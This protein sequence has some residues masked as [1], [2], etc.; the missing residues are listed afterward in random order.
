MTPDSV[1]YCIAFAKSREHTVYREQAKLMLE[2]L[3]NVGYFF[4]CAVVFTNIKDSPLLDEL[5]D[6]PYATQIREVILD[7]DDFSTGKDGKLPAARFRIDAWQH[8]DHWRGADYVLYLDTDCIIRKPLSC[9]TDEMDKE[10]LDIMGATVARRNMLRSRWFNGHIPPILDASAAITSPV[11]SGTIL[12][13]G[14]SFEPLCRL[15]REFDDGPGR[16]GVPPHLVT[17]QSSHNLLHLLSRLDKIPFRSGR[18]SVHGVA[19]PH[20]GQR[21]ALGHF[22]VNGA[23]IWHFWHLPSQEDRVVAMR[24]ELERLQRMRHPAPEG[25]LGVWS[26]EKPKEKISNRWMFHECGLIT[27]D[28]PALCGRWEWRPSESELTQNEIL[29]DWLWGWEKIPLGYVQYT[30]LPPRLFGESFRNGAFT[31]ERI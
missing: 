18:F 7:W 1:V 8:F 16:P 3:F 9:L 29:I 10:G 11:Q 15:W 25:L 4:G 31:L 20:T 6:K 19:C 28:K 22:A 13:D 14:P 21:E 12:F 5:R 30:Q 27:V 23:A 2:S 26:H 24:S 17:D